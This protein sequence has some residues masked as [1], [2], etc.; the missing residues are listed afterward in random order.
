M[1]DYPGRLSLACVP[2][3]FHCLDRLSA[4]IGGPRI[5]IKRDDLTGCLTSGNKVRKLEFILAQA[6]AD[7]C[8]ALIT[9][10]GTQS[11]HCR[12][13][14]VL[15]AQLGLKVHLLLRTDSGTHPTG[16][17]LVDMLAGATIN[18][19]SAEQF[20]DLSALYERWSD[21]YSARGYKPKVIP[22]GGSNA[23]GLWGYIAAVEELKNDFHRAKI[24]PTTIIHASGSGGTQA[25]LIA[26]IKLHKLESNI[27]G[28][29]VCDDAGYF[30]NKIHTDLTAWQNEYSV[31]I[32]VDQLPIVTNDKHI[33]LGYGQAG[34]EVFQTIRMVAAEEGVVLD[35]VY[36]GK[37]FHGMLEEIKL[38]CHEQE[39]DI[40]FVHTGGIFG[41]LAQQEQLQ[42]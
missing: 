40:V 16:N 15:G 10:G 32:N 20:S 19:Y 39:K 30:H 27:C 37:A 8:D 38:G 26:G 9:A 34:P 36:S 1:V 25:G 14:A 22:V 28:Y 4:R 3:P 41:L 31:N 17:L 7:G 23:T 24:N 33:G 6:M 13:V 11:N 42:F 12:A 29:A 2:T 18:H 35:P 5:W 21:H